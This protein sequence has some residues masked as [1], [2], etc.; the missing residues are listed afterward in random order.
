[1][2]AQI[3]SKPPADCTT[4]HAH[5]L[6]CENLDGRWVCP[7]CV[8]TI[9][10]GMALDIR[11]TAAPSV[12]REGRVTDN[13][14]RTPAT[15]MQE[16]QA[17]AREGG[18][19]ERPSI[20]RGPGRSRLSAP[21]TPA[22]T[23]QPL[24]SSGVGEGVGEGEEGEEM[25]LVDLPQQMRPDGTAPRTGE[26][27]QIQQQGPRIEE[28]SEELLEAEAGDNYTRSSQQKRGADSAHPGRS[29]Y[30]EGRSRKKGKGNISANSASARKASRLNLFSSPA[31]TSV[32]PDGDE[33]GGKLEE[34][35]GEEAGEGGSQQR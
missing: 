29:A 1:M 6:L 10:T 13:P 30:H 9:I 12:D 14:L 16:Q 25:I 15:A 23:T 4:S 19:G 32:N 21:A 26:D 7:I 33:E 34:S 20:E 31:S 5:V 22:I 28:H 2:G 11:A 27:R 17:V 24:D 8:S 3:A 18:E 35:T